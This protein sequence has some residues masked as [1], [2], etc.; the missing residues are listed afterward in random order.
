MRFYRPP[1]QWGNDTL[2]GDEARHALKVLRVRQG[3]SIELFD[4]LGRV[5]RAEVV[6]AASKRLRYRTTEECEQAPVTPRIRLFQAIPKGKT[7][8]LIIQKAVELGVAE[9]HPLITQNTVAVSDAPEKKADKWQRVALEAA[10]QCQ[11]AWLPKV[12]LPQPLTPALEL[13]DDLPLVASLRPSAIPM[14]QVVETAPDARSISLLIG[15]E[16]DFTDEELDLIEARGVC[17]I[18]LGDLV[19]RSETVS[20]Y[21]LSA[22]RFYNY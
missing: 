9:I 2:E 19:L 17:P 14:R 21:S 3:E 1:E 11:Q 7:M 6:E 20:I 12:Q 5:A 4:G 8:D 18:S 16:G 15:P 22:L 10:K 13:N